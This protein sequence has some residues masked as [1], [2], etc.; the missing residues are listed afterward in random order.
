MEDSVINTGLPVQRYG[1]YGN[2]YDR[3]GH[4]EERAK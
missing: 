4:E 2:D 3:F 1:T